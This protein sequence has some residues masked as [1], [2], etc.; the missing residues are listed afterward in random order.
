MP[1]SAASRRSSVTPPRV[2]G[3]LIPAVVTAHDEH[4]ITAIGEDL[5]HHRRHA[6]IRATNEIRAGSCRVGQRAEDV[7][8]RRHAEL[9]A[10]GRGVLHRRMQHLRKRKRDTQFSRT[11]RDRLRAEVDGDTEL[12]EHISGAALRRGRTIPVLDNR[13]SARR[14][15]DRGHRGEVDRARRVTTGAD[16]IEQDP[17]HLDPQ[18]HRAHRFGRARDLRG[19]GALG[20][21]PEE[22]GLDVVRI[23]LA[24][25]DLLDGPAGRVGVEVKPAVE[26]TE[27]RPPGGRGGTGHRSPRKGRSSGA[28][29][30]SGQ[31]WSWT[32]KTS[33]SSAEATVENLFIS[34]NSPRSLADRQAGEALAH[35]G[36]GRLGQHHGVQGPRH[37]AVGP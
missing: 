18:C 27:H 13:R 6:R 21:H 22:E 16:D 25:H 12:L 30:A 32:R 28:R 35:Q 3:D 14:R 34:G 15:D 23:G 1:R 19:R 9:T 29:R 20:L 8:D 4:A 11:R 33:R 24:R 26:A 31:K 7:E 37:D 17:R 10:D 5:R 36:G 2:R